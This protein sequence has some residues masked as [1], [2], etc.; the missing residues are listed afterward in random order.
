MLALRQCLRSAD[1]RMREGHVFPKFNVQ[2]GDG[3]PSPV[4]E[5]ADRGDEDFAFVFDDAVFG[6]DLQFPDALLLV[7]FGPLYSMSTMHVSIQIETLDGVLEVP[8]YLIATRVESTPVR[9]RGERERVDMRR[10]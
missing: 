5:E 9:I 4:G 1:G 10:Y 6:F 7:E 3:W 8:P 2:G